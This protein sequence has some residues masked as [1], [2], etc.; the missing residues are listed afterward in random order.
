MEAVRRPVVGASNQQYKHPLPGALGEPI[1]IALDPCQLFWRVLNRTKSKM[2]R[3]KTV[4]NRD[5]S[6]L[7]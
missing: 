6:Q 3:H 4:R 7:W 1:Q 2:H 5:T